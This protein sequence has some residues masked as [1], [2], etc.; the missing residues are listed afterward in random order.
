VQVWFQNR[1][2]KEKRLRRDVGRHVSRQHHLQQHQQQQQQQQSGHDGR[3]QVTA[4]SDCD[5]Y[6][7]ETSNDY[8]ARK[9][10]AMTGRAE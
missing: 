2:A 3:D 9:H 8:L 4:D 5:D 7:S 10:T 6:G 1:R